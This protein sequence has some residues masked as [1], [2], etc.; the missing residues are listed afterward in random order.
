M[1]ALKHS[2]VLSGHCYRHANSPRHHACSAK[3][4]QDENTYRRPVTGAKLVAVPSRSWPV[5]PGYR[6]KMGIVP[7]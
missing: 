3:E 5:C 1:A 2:L 7:S 4:Q 6:D